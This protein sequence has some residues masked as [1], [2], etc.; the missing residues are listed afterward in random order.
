VGENTFHFAL[1]E[2]AGNPPAIASR[3]YAPVHTGIFGLCSC[4]ANAQKRGFVTA[5]FSPTLFEFPAIAQ[6]HNTPPGRLS[7]EYYFSRV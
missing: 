4:G 3:I 6:P 5:G 2:S 1:A 7:G